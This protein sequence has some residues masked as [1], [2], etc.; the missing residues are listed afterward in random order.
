[1]LATTIAA[2][3]AAVSARPEGAR[4]LASFLK[5]GVSGLG[6]GRPGMLTAVSGCGRLQLLPKRT[7]LEARVQQPPSLARSCCDLGSGWSASSHAFL[8]CVSCRCQLR[9]RTAFCTVCAAFLA[10]SARFVIGS[11]AISDWRRIEKRRLT[12]S[13]L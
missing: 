2:E 11:G 4:K 5:A 1:M 13:E 7:E 10:S 9:R 3:L 6:V 12:L 8:V